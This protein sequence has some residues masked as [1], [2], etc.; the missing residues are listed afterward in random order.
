MAADPTSVVMRLHQAL[1]AHDLDAFV[2]CFS[3]AYRSE[4]PAHPNRAFGGYAQ[5]RTNWAAIFASVPD[6][7]AE[8]LGVVADGGTVWSEW[9][10]NGQRHDGSTLD[11]RGVIVFGIANDLI[12]W[13]RLYMEET[14]RNGAGIYDTVR[15]IARTTS[16]S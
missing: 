4:Q 9:A 16:E 7:Q 8:L 2:A 15:H 12:A 13:A 14:E 10:W 1:N 3:P 5:V 6:F 11:M